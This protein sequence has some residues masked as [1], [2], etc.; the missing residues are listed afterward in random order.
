MKKTTFAAI[1]ALL[2]SVAASA[3]VA[4][5]TGPWNKLEGQHSRIAELRTVAVTDAAAWEKVW[6]EHDASSPVPAVNFSE[7]SVV[8]VFLGETKTAGVK[9][10]IVVQKDMIDSG[11]LNVFYKEVRPASKPFA[12]AVICRPFAMVK[13]PKAK[14]VSFEADGRV[15]VPEETKAPKNPRDDVKFRALLETLPSFDGR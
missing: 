6:K 2:L 15:S 5:M 10:E 14:T 1:A 3:Q 4:Q 7:E 8:A 12:A 9:I 11:R 13:V